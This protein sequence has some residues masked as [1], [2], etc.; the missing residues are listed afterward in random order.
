MY[1]AQ[2]KAT[3]QAR[4]NAPA[5]PRSNTHTNQAGAPT[6]GTRINAAFANQRTVFETEP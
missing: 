5:V 4:Q 1:Q 2:P 6:L 3:S